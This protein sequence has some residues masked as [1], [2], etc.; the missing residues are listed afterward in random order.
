MRTYL[1][2]LKIYLDTCCYSRPYDDERQP[3]I[4]REV[5]AIE[6]IIDYLQ[7]Q[8]WH[9]ITSEVIVFE[10]NRNPNLT[11]REDIKKLLRNAHQYVSVGAT[12]ELRSEQLESFG[13][14][15]LDA[16]HI[17][18]AENANA[19][20]LLTTDRWMLKRA[21][22]YHFQL[23]VRLENPHIWLGE[24][25]P[26]RVREI[27][28]VSMEKDQCEDTELRALLDKIFQY[29]GG[30]GDYSIDRHEWMDN[31]DLDTILKGIRELRDTEQNN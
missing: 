27:Q 23:R 11:Q 12:E 1:Q 25:L 7:I 21:K 17:A 29:K 31:L 5:T 4:F 16:L 30:K 24:V 6:T 13:F 28:V 26:M 14:K 2:S 18:C 15:P 8:Q 22:N 3:E 19:D 10:V 9:W 20:I